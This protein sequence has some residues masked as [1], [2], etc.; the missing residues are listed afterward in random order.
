[1]FL[2]IL[3]A[4]C[5]V[6]YAGYSVQY[7]VCS[8]Y[9]AVCSMQYAVCSMQYAHCQLT[10]GSLPCSSLDGRAFG[11]SKIAN[12]EIIFCGYFKTKLFGKAE[13]VEG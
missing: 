2:H 10:G 11:Q 6:H 3:R 5:S 8:V 9:Y 7:S 4:V 13:E 12:I 1:M